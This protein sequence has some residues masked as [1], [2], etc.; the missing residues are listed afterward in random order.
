MD[1]YYNTLPMS[2]TKITHAEMCHLR[3]TISCSISEAHL[4]VW[5]EN[6]IDFG[7]QGTKICYL[8]QNEGI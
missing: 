1:S 6:G 4:R 7:E 5:G 8:E 3:V 2:M